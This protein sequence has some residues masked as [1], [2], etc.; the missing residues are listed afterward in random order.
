MYKTSDKSFL[1]IVICFFE[2][3]ILYLIACFYILTLKKFLIIP[4]KQVKIYIVM[5][6][7]YRISM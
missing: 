6:N 4:Q 5:Q 2:N 1:N 7:K 3:I